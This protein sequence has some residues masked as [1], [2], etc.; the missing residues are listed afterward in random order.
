MARASYNA[1]AFSLPRKLVTMFAGANDSMRQVKYRNIAL[2]GCEPPA[3]R[4]PLGV[5][6]SFF[7]KKLVR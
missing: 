2:G 6:H 7:A 5:F 1:L 3:A 4:H